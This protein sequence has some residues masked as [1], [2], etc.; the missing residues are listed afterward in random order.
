MSVDEEA[1][2]KTLLPQTIHKELRKSLLPPRD[3]DW[4]SKE[5]REAFLKSLFHDIRTKRYTPSVPRGYI[6]QDKGG[7]V[8]RITPVLAYRDMCVYY[9]CIVQLQEK[10]AVNRVPGTFGGWQLGNPMRKEEAA[11]H[12]PVEAPYTSTYSLDPYKWMKYWKE[13]QRLALQKSRPGHFQAFIE[14]DIAN[15]YDTVN[16]DLLEKSILG[17][18]GNDLRETVDLLFVLLRTW[19]RQ[20]QG[21]SSKTIGLP[22]EESADCSRI[23]ANFFLQEYDF[24]VAEMCKAESQNCDYLRYS[25]DQ[26]ILAESIEQARKILVSCCKNLHELGLNVGASKVHEFQNREDY[27]YYWTFEIMGLLDDES[28]TAKVNLAAEMFNFYRER[29]LRRVDPRPWR[30]YSV[31]RRLVSVG[32]HK[33]EEST[34][35]S[36]ATRM[37][38]P[39]AVAR[40]DEFM[41]SGVA[42]GISEAE[43]LEFFAAIDYCVPRVP[44]NRFHLSLRRFFA[45]YGN[46]WRSVEEIDLRIVE[47]NNYWS[48]EGAD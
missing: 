46:P 30:W 11:E 36:I 29:Q 10:L 45:K 40:M 15:F 9:F 22:Q 44:F 21:Y 23:L 14:F 41:L 3:G 28:D 5:Q 19:N 1:F 18:C 20:Y 33:I 8:P 2:Y 34:R 42:R 37:I 32:L 39:E 6:V 43:R 12:R 27:D 26:I 17:A 7:H 48:P 25:D 4:P 24:A 35:K 38:E 47:L 31:E 16:L 13:F